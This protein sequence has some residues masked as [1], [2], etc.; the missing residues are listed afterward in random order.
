MS[1]RFSPRRLPLSRVMHEVISEIGWLKGGNDE[2]VE[3]LDGL[4]EEGLVQKD[5]NMYSL[6]EKG[7]HWNG[8]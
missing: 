8:K 4:I 7:I 5:G 1:P 2:L 6:T 3:R